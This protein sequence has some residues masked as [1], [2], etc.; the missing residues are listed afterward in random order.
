[1]K[2]NALA[3]KFAQQNITTADPFGSSE[4]SVQSTQKASTRC[5][6][7]RANSCAAEQLRKTLVGLLKASLGVAAK[8][9]ASEASQINKFGQEIHIFCPNCVSN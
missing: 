7:S 6:C 3:K 2:G 5:F 8:Q 9:Q 4:T 1:L